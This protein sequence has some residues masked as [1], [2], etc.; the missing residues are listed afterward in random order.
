MKLRAQ[1]EAFRRA[2][3]AAG[4]P[5]LAYRF[6]ADHLDEVSGLTLREGSKYLP[7]KEREELRRRYESREH[8]EKKR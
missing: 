4:T 8:E 3:H 7:A 6:L 1:I 5:E 2:F